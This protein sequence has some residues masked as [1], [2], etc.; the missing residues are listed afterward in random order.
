MNSKQH[1]KF[2]LFKSG[3]RIL[4]CALYLA[5]GDFIAGFTVSMFIVAEIAGVIEE[6]VDER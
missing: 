2:S 3:L 6:F 5:F 1:L 4:G